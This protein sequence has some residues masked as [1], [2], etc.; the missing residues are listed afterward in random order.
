MAKI[1]WEAYGPS[2]IPITFDHESFVGPTENNDAGGPLAVIS[3]DTDEES[4]ISAKCIAYLLNK[5]GLKK[6]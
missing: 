4:L 2:K 3:G 6:I 5:H 1:L